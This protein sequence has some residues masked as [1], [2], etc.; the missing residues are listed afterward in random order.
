MDNIEQEKTLNEYINIL[1]KRKWVMLITTSVIILVVIFFNIVATPTYKAVTTILISPSNVQSSIF[2]GTKLNPIFGGS[3]EIETHIAILKS[4]NIAQGVAE[5]LP[6]DV[7]DTIHEKIKKERLESLK[8][9]FS[10]IYKV[11]LRV[12]NS[13]NG[14]NS[15]ISTDIDDADAI[16]PQI[17]NNIKQV[18]NSLFINAVKDTNM[19]EISCES[20]DPILSAN[21]ANTTAEVFIDKFLIINRSNASEATKFIE[22]QLQEK[23]KELAAQEKELQDVRNNEGIEDRELRLADLERTV[24]VSE[25]I[26]LLLLEK[27]QESRINEVM[28]FVDIRIIDK[29][30]PPETSIKPRKVLNLAIGIAL[31]IIV[32]ALLSFFLEY[33][34]HTIKNS[35]DVE[36]V[37]NL[38]VLGII[39]KNS[40]KENWLKTKKDTT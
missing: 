40:I 32:G 35:K 2:G 34:D 26:Y 16:T 13:N 1:L 37:L 28:E 29:A 33:T 3:D 36:N 12:Q 6:T 8:W 31:G 30:L 24:R 4:Y 22:E 27:Y 14:N 23:E 11:F 39:P 18:R 17:R 21:I 20:I 7:Y 19:I 15:N 5:K 10:L 25:N 9:P 38:P